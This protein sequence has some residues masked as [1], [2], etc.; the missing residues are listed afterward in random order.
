MIDDWRIDDSIR[1]WDFIKIYHQ[2]G[3]EVINGNQNIKF[4]F[5]QNLSYTQIGNGHLE[6]DK[7]VKEVDITIY[8]NADPSW[9]VSNGLACTFQKNRLSTRSGTETANNKNLGPASTITRLLLQ[10]DRDLS[11]YFDRIDEKE[12]SIFN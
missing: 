2:H 10:K 1:K 11:S 6:N 9:L 8:S 5:G 3:A 12:A 4:H 7:E